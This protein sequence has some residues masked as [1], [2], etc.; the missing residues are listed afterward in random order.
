MLCLCHQFLVCPYYQFCLLV[1]LVS[2]QDRH[3][4]LKVPFGTE[5]VQF[6]AGYC[7]PLSDHSLSDMPCFAK[8]AFLDHRSC[9]ST[10]INYSKV[11]NSIEHVCTIIAILL[12]THSYALN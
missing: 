10:L 7:G 12:P 8:Y 9:L 1:T 6:T 2:T 3:H 4:V 11:P 5:S